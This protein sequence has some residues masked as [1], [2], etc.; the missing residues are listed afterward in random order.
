MAVQ[1]TREVRPQLDTYCYGCHSGE[2]PKGGLA[3]TDY[4][5]LRDAREDGATWTTVLENLRSHRMPPALADHKLPAHERN[6][7][8]TL[9][10]DLVF[11]ID[12]THPD[13]GAV[14]LRRL[15]RTEYNRTVRDLVGIDFFPAENFPSDDSG[16]GFDN[17]GDVLMLPPV[18]ME[19]YLEA[20]DQIIDRAIITEPAPPIRRRYT[21][22]ELEIGFN[23]KGD[24]GDGWLQLV[25]LEEDDAG[26]EVEIPSPGDYQVRVRAFTE[27]TG[28]VF[29]M[30]E[31]QRVGEPDNTDPPPLMT[32]SVDDA[33]AATFEVTAREPSP[34]VYE[35]RVGLTAGRHRIRAFN[36]RLRGGRNE[37]VVANGR[38]GKQQQSVLFVQWVEIEGP[39]PGVLRR[40]P[41]ASLAAT[42]EARPYENS[43]WILRG[44]AE[45]SLPLQFSQ[46][47][48]CIVRIDA[49][50][51]QAGA[52]PVRLEL[53]LD[54]QPVHTFDVRAPGYAALVAGKRLRFE[55][56]WL[57]PRPQI[58]ET[59]LKMKPGKHT[60]SAAFINDFE[61]P[62]APLASR[63]DRNLVVRSIETVDLTGQWAPPPMPGPIQRLFARNDGADAAS[64][65][66]A[67]GILADFAFRAWRRPVTSREADRLLGLYELASAQQLGFRESLKVVFKAV[68]VSPDFLFRGEVQ[69]ERDPPAGVHPI[70]EFA[71]ASRLSYFLWSSMPDEELFDLARAGRLRQNLGAQVRRMLASPK[72][73]ALA[74]NFAGQWLQTRNLEAIYPDQRL[75]P[76]YNEWIR[77]D[78]REE[79]QRFFLHV[80]Q[81]NRSLMDFI[82][83]DYT[84]LNE[85]LATFYGIPGV[86]GN[87]FRR[88]SLAGTPRRGVL[89][90][91]SVL[92]L[93]SNPSRTSPV[94]RGKWVLETL[95]GAPPPPPPPDIP[96]LDDEKHALT[97][98][99]RERMQQHRANP[100]CASC[101]EQMDQIGFALEN[102][103]AIGAWRDKDGANPIDASGVLNGDITF[104][105]ATELCAVLADTR[106]GDFLRCVVEKMLT[107]ALGRGV[108]AY[109]RPA[110]KQ[111]VQKLEADGDRFETLVQG[112]VESVPFQQHRGGPP[113]THPAQQ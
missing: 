96:A 62:G 110:V 17:I 71:L 97:G 15:N 41:A 30:V 23:A 82:A 70:N 7:L 81:E 111:I 48:D 69:S 24:R 93:S 43:A 8:A 3:L 104:S 28:G 14:T 54:G 32:V 67:R 107:Y 73:V 60:L 49:F 63:R 74:E 50:G 85:R 102:F 35:A 21:S 18:L 83:G 11:P 46:E 89:T 13:P 36:P 113:D 19:R 22:K 94:K 31:S 37:L 98:T 51:D 59:R 5:S 66:A 47:T 68:L 34:G 103:N 1:F 27:P 105:G 112:I 57:L 95:L 90:Q 40:Y 64:P 16:Y 29:H 79:T 91:G 100:A 9:I 38:L 108:E 33:K 44:P 106:R 88:V 56:T 42:G 99:L 39:V 45:V 52:D 65:R 80:M 2:K 87:D 92:L 76:E 4:V 72:S 61:D 109:D 26:F 53:R 20:A 101:H 77:D 10:D 6:Q 58:Y 84:Y 55:K 75:F 25:S 86:K 78:L 12:A